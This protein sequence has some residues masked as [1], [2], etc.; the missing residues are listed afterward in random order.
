MGTLLED[1]EKVVDQKIIDKQEKRFA[2]IKEIL[3]KSYY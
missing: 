2:K 1:K 3:K